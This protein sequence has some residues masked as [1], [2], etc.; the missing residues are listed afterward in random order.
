MAAPRRD[1]VLN[2]QSGD[3]SPHSK[4][5][6]EALDAVV[7]GIEDEHPALG[8]AGDAPGLVELAGPAAIRPKVADVL[9][10]E[11]EF[12]HAVVAELAQI[13]VPIRLSGKCGLVEQDVVGVM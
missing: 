1:P 7:V 8:I 2:S 12:L 6:P 3:E 13:D 4:S 11:R 9:P 5:E 10:I